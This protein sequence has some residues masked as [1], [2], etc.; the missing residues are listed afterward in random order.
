MKLKTHFRPKNC[1]QIKMFFHCV[2]FVL[3]R[4]GG[5]SG[6]YTEGESELYGSHI[7]PRIPGHVSLA[8]APRDQPDQSGLV[9]SAGRQREPL[10]PCA[11]GASQV[12]YSFVNLFFHERAEKNFPSFFFFLLSPR[13]I[14]CENAF[15]THPRVFCNN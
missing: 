1:I 7:G 2:N 9:E 15:I 14:R 3:K 8:A 11:S 13:K 12:C 4:S 6:G 10:R 5:G